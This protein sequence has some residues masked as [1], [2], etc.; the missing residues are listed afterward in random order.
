MESVTFDVPYPPPRLPLSAFAGILVG[1]APDGLVVGESG[2]VGA[3]VAAGAGIGAGVSLYRRIGAVAGS[4][5][6][7][8]EGASG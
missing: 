3:T 5:A 2:A 4:G 7:D 8:G 1:A 6:F